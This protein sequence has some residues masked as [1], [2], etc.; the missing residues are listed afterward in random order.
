[1]DMRIPVRIGDGENLADGDVSLRVV[2]VDHVQACDC[3]P[4]R[5][6]AGAALGRLF[7][8]RA[9]NETAWF[10]RVIVV[11][12]DP[13]AEASVLAALREDPIASARFRLES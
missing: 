6:N 1:M 8:A 5:G 2:A 13:A 9:R 11:C 12:G 3:C 10:T 7:A 4:P